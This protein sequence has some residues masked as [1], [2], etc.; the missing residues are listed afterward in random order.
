MQ[1]T[2][3]VDHTQTCPSPILATTKK[4]SLKV[5]KN[6]F[7]RRFCVPPK[8][9]SVCFQKSGKRNK[10]RK[11]PAS[12]LALLSA[13]ARAARSALQSLGLDSCVDLRRIGGRMA[14]PR[15]PACACVRRCCTCVRHRRA[16]ACVRPRLRGRE[17]SK[18]IIERG[19]KMAVGGERRCDLG[20]G[21]SYIYIYIRYVIGPM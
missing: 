7:G 8:R 15:L 9:F 3:T 1:K 2:K 19:I 11:S 21:S 5:A 20:F 13:P 6:D 14:P 18:T 4:A 16:C 17:P 10:K 12:P